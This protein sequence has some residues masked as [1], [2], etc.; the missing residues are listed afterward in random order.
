MKN[1]FTWPNNAS[2][3]V[4]LTYDDGLVSQLDN[5]LPVLKE[6]GVKGT[7]FLSGAALTDAALGGRWKQA[8]KDGHE[9][10]CHTIHHACDM[11]HEFVRKGYSL[12][13][14]SFQRM[15]EELEENKRII[16]GY[17]YKPKDYV[18][19]YPCGESALGP[20]MAQSYKPLIAE[21]FIAARGVTG[22]YAEAGKFDLMETPCFEAPV[23]VEGLISLV[24]K[25]K[26]KKSWAIILF[27]GVGGD[28][29][30]VTKEVHA[31]FIKYLAGNRKTVYT[32]TFGAMAGIIK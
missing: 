12:Q 22:K 23:T 13:D 9:L 21:M 17:G 5:A 10:G 26:E 27:H 3:A 15:R 32:D 28:Y 19:A 11:K 7:F 30:S 16:N 25:A 4:S 8:V 20:G 31:V 29:I 24:E 1:N 18:F 14:Y 6:H 2:C